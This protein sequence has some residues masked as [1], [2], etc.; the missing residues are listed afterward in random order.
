MSQE[1]L[2]S[3]QMK[4][5]V[6]N[7]HEVA[8]ILGICRTAAFAAIARG[9]IFA[10]RIGRRLLVPKSAIDQLLAVKPKRQETQSKGKPRL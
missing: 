5:A 7:V 10:V 3:D 4:P 2:A 8:E 1:N 9:E 6:Y